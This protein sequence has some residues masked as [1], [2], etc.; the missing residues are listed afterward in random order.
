MTENNTGNRIKDS[1]LL[2]VGALGVVAAA[3]TNSVIFGIGRAADVPFE[4]ANGG[5]EETINVGMVAFMTTA[6]FVVGLVGV[7]V[8]YRFFGRRSLRPFAVLGVVLALASN[9]DFPNV[10]ASV[11][12]KWLLASMHLVVGLA[13]LISLEVVR[14]RA[15]G[16]AAAGSGDAEVV[17]SVATA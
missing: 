13:Y 11:G 6:S 5:S 15:V 16:H 17:P 1:G 4:V 8:A 9:V 3:V 2:K 7:V 14:S 10:E 12:T